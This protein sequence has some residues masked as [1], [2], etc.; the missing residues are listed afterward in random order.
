MRNASS[1]SIIL[2]VCFKQPRCLNMTFLSSRQFTFSLNVLLYF[3]LFYFI[4]HLLVT[5]T[6]IMKLHRQTDYE[7]YH[8]RPARVVL[9]NHNEASRLA[10]HFHAM[11]NKHFSLLTSSF[12]PGVLEMM[13]LH[14]TV[15]A[16]ILTGTTYAVESKAQSGSC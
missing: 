10:A 14:I 9:A 11:P 13:L 15:P 4:S 8:A 12:S 3:I 6:I 1:E 2:L 16:I 5:G 7:I